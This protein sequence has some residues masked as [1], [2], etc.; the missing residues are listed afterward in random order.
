MNRKRSFSPALAAAA[1]LAVIVA[2]FAIADPADDAKPSPQSEFQLPEGWTQEDMEACMIAGTPGKEHEQL[3]KSHAGEWKGKTTLWMTSESE[4]IHSECTYTV[5]PIMD[6][7]YLM[8]KMEG[9]FPGMG[10]YSGAGVIGFDNLKQ[11][12]VASWIDNHSTGILN[13]VG[14]L[15]SDGRKLTWEYK[16]ICPVTKKPTVMREVETITGPNSKTM[17]MYGTDP[18]AGKEYKMMHV[19]FTRT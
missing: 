9:E 17:E 2:P 6:G 18:K 5:T 1:L 7:R 13:G 19:E 12:Y 3:A 8:G 11:Q 15:S 10:P 16:H 4:P 14:E